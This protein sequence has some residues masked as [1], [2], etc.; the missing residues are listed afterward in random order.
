MMF[1]NVVWS[2][3]HPLPFFHIIYDIMTHHPKGY[4]KY[5]L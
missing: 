1:G 3:R 2:D 5:L 4:K